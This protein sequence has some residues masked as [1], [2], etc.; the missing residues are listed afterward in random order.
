MEDV[1][2]R[3]I[4]NGVH[5]LSWLTPQMQQLYDRY[6][7]PSRQKNSGQSG[8]WEDVDKIE[9]GEFWETHITLK[10]QML[11]FVRSRAV[12]Q[13]ERRSEAPGHV[14]QR[15]RALGMDALTI[16]V[17]R[18]FAAYERADLLFQDIDRVAELISD[19]RRR[20]TIAMARHSTKHSRMKSSRSSTT[21]TACLG[22]GSNE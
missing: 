4:T 14:S 17:A 19:P 2:I 3:Q 11:E 1:P 18:R 9:D 22:L 12:R 8:A 13:A 6:L 21:A 15:K 7:G 5:V 16:G 20:T 10:A